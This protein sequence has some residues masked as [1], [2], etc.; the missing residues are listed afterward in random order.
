MVHV[1]VASFIE[2]LQDEEHL[3][4]ARLKPLQMRKVSCIV[5]YI[6]IAAKRATTILH[7]IFNHHG[8]LCLLLL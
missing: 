6:D 2:Y 3:S 8:M 5:D 4:I 7:H 1:D